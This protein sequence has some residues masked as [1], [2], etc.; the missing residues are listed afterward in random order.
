MLRIQAASQKSRQFQVLP[1]AG[2]FCELLLSVPIADRRGFLF[3]L[4]PQRGEDHGDRML[5]HH[6]SKM[7]SRFGKAA[8]VM[9][10]PE[11]F[12]SAHDLRRSFGQRWARKVSVNE[13]RHL[14]RHRDIKTTAT[15]YLALD[16]EATA[17][18]ARVGNTIG[19]GRPES[20]EIPPKTSG[21]MKSSTD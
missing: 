10:G 6:V 7:I 17:R 19:N 18:A 21:K 5:L 1:L 4:V 3:N 12:A 15:F 16:A 9:V 14:M 2:D 11:K 13:L 20:S 8:G